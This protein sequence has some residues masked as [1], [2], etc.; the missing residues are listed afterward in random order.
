MKIGEK[1]DELAAQKIAKWM[2]E[3][4]RL[5]H[6]ATG[7][8]Q[9]CTATSLLPEGV[10]MMLG[11]TIE[12][13]DDWPDKRLNWAKK[14][15]REAIKHIRVR[16]AGNMPL[17]THMLIASMIGER[18]GYEKASEHVLQVATSLWLKGSD[19]AAICVRDLGQV[20][21]GK[22]EEVEER[23]LKINRLKLPREQDREEEQE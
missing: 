2:L 9:L 13:E 7:G 12:A 22:A 15:I 23:M 10:L 17:D 1:D 14:I 11:Y 8:A 3:N 16:I 18:T 5:D 6:P 21:Q 20:L 4:L 19:A